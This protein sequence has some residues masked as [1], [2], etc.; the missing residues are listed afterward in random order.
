LFGSATLPH[1]LILKAP[2]A[3]PILIRTPQSL[4][5]KRTEL[6]IPNDGRM[7]PIWAVDRR[8]AHH[9]IVK[10]RIF[11]SNGNAV[12]ACCDAIESLAIEFKSATG[13]IRLDLP[14]VRQAGG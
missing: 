4:R 11:K 10:S 1:L 8:S 3:R 12:A 13:P 5:G 9:A 2:L 14:F 7:R 6:S